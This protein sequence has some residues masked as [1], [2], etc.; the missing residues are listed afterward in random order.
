MTEGTES[1]WPLLIAW[2]WFQALS[3]NTVL[4]LAARSPKL[5]GMLNAVT[6]P[7]SS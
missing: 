3:R 6:L 7:V 4:V 2:S 1:Y 5:A